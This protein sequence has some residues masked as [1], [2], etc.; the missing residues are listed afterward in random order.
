MEVKLTYSSQQLEDA[1]KFIS[2]NNT[3]FLGQS[4][5][6]RDEILKH[7][8]EIARDPEAWSGG[9]MGY[10]LIGDRTDE[11][12]DSDENT[13]HFDITVDPALGRDHEDTDYIEEI[14][15]G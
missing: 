11:G 12:M 5:Y 8:R 15:Y 9:T 3:H 7:M 2:R 1:V 14:V 10:M 6:I 13:I 4:D